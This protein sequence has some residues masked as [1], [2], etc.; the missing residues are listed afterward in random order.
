MA[1]LV[2]SWSS[3]RIGAD[4]STISTF[5]SLKPPV[6]MVLKSSARLGWTFF[7]PSLRSL[8]S[9]M[10]LLTFGGFGGDGAA[11]GGGGGGAG[12]KIFDF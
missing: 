10:G 5:F 4:L 12:A 6:L 8:G 9:V 11:G 3:V 2:V 1:I 7:P